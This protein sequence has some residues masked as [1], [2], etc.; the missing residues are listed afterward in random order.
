[1]ATVQYHFSKQPRDGDGSDDDGDDEDDDD[2]DDD[3]EDDDDDDEDDDEDEDD[4]DEDEPLASI[5]QVIQV[6]LSACDGHSLIWFLRIVSSCQLLDDD[7][8]GGPG[9]GEFATAAAQ[10]NQAPASIR[11]SEEKTR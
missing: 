11:Y 9:A 10:N 5:G 6:V 3:D 7:E 2:D 1:M 4:E 8:V